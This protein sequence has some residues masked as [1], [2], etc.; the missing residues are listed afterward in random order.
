MPKR[1]R[2]SRRRSTGGG[3]LSAQQF[4]NPSQPQP[5]A[6]MLAPVV[7]SAPTAHEVRPVLYSTFQA[8]AGRKTRRSG[9]KTRGGFS[10]SVMGSFI[11]NAQSAIVPLALYAVYHLV[12][13]KRGSAS[14]AGGRKS[15]KSGRRRV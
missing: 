2:S 14:A 1:T 12:V 9:R 8:G 7:T 3:Y 11:A 5:V 15:R 10:P 4:F 6:S 13:P